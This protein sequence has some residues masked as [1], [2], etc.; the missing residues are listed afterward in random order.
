MKLNLAAELLETNGKPA[1]FVEDI[2]SKPRPM[3]IKD[4][5]LKLCSIQAAG[6]AK[7][8]F[9]LWRLAMTVVGCDAPEVDLGVKVS[10]VLLKLAKNPT[11]PKGEAVISQAAQA[12]LLIACGLTEDDL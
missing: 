10:D 8:S 2:D 7:A 4:L 5:I 12:Q 6:E 3:T 9:M 11:G 1:M